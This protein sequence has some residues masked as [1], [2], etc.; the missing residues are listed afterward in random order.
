MADVPYEVVSGLPT[1]FSGCVR[2]FFINYKHIVLNENSIVHGRNIADCDGTPCGADVCSNG[3]TC[4]L[5]TTLKPH[6][7]CPEVSF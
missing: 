4:W 5:N 6:C 7:M 2:Q 3:G 1:S